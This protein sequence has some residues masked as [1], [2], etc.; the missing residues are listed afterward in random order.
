MTSLTSPNTIMMNINGLDE[1]GN[2]TENTMVQTNISF[3]VNVVNLNIGILPDINVI[4]HENHENHENHEIQISHQSTTIQTRSRRRLPPSIVVVSSDDESGQ[5]MQT[6]H[7]AQPTQAEEQD[8]PTNINSIK[9]N[10]R[11]KQ[12]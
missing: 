7:V 12:H 11:N 8:S 3:N 1:S 9:E 6:M 4:L 5:A 2:T 10:I